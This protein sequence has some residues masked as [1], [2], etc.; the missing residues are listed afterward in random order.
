MSTPSLRT[1]PATFTEFLK[2]AD[3]VA[4]ATLIESG[5]FPGGIDRD[6]EAYWSGIYDLARVGNSWPETDQDDTIHMQEHSAKMLAAHMVGL[7]LGLRLRGADLTGGA[8]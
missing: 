6:C 1:D 7:A 3:A 8:R 2:A 4:L 5:V